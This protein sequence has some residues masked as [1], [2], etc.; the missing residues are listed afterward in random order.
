MRASLP[1]LSATAGVYDISY[2]FYPGGRHEML[3]EINRGEVRTR[4]L[5][6]ISSILVR[7]NGQPESVTSKVR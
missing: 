5:R 2:D 3:N 1:A 6:W 4:L 7:R